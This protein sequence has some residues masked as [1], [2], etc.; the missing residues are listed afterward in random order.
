VRAASIGNM[1]QVW[2]N[3]GHE[4][5]WFNPAQAEGRWF[6]Q[7]ATQVKNIWVPYGRND[8]AVAL[9]EPIE[10][11]AFAHVRPANDCHRQAVMDN[12]AARE[13]DLKSGERRCDLADAPSDLGLRRHV[14]VVFGKVDARFEQRNQFH[15]R[16]L[17]RRSAAAERTAH[18]AG[19]LARL[20]QRLRFDQVANRFGL[21]KVQSARQ[22]ST[23]R[24]FAG[25]GQPCAQLQCASKQKLQHHRRPMRSNLNQIFRRVRIRRAEESHKSFV[26][27]RETGART[28]RICRLLHGA[29]SLP[30]IDHVGQSGMSVLKGLMGPHEHRGNRRG[31]RPTQAH[32]SDA[33][34]PRR[35]GDRSDGV[36]CGARFEI[37]RGHRLHSV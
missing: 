10:K 33:A 14:D 37:W 35:R 12:A 8:S 36:S 30:E 2:T 34:P 6:L 15:E 16:L 26:N 5:D 23:L 24:E 18:L 29:R 11:R 20:R 3:D 27:A 25:L 9:D 31:L 21:R 1:K 32:D 17:G 19:S 13:R 22:K 28:F 7:H 4:Y